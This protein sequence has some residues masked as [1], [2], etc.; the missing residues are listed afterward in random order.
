MAIIKVTADMLI[1]KELEATGLIAQHGEA[2]EKIRQIVYGLNTM[3]KGDAQTAFVRVFDEMDPLFREFR[4]DLE[5]YID[6]MHTTAEEFRATD[7]SLGNS[8][9]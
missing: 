5:R 4:A 3:W 2:I 8:F 6:L 9:S 1:N 7:T